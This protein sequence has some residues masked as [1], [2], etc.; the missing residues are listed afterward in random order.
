MALYC[1]IKKSSGGSGGS[2]GSGFGRGFGF[3]IDFFI[4]NFFNDFKIL[5]IHKYIKCFNLIFEIILMHHN[6]LINFFSLKKI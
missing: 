4:K 6:A 3:I 2:R 1:W 5:E